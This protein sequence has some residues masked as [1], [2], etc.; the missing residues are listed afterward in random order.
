M[1]SPPYCLAIPA[2]VGNGHILGY[3]RV[4]TDHVGQNWPEGTAIPETFQHVLY[5]AVQ[6]GAGRCC[7]GGVSVWLTILFLF[8]GGGG[9]DE[10][11]DEEKGRTPVSLMLKW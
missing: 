1:V 4:V 7:R 2:V 3:V 11:V 5:Q 10:I 6:V 8:G 9:V